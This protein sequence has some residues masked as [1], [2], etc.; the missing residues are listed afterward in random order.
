MS[1]GR[2]QKKEEKKKPQ[3]TLKEKRAEK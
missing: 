2:D 3:K 1:K